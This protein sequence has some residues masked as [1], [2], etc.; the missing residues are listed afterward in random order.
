MIELQTSY[1]L[2]RVPYITFEALDDYAEDLI[3]D[4]MPELL[5]TPGWLNTDKFLEY[6][7]GLQA[8]YH[9]ICYDRKILGITAFSDG[10]LRV[11]DEDSGR[12]KKLPV[13]KGTVLIDSSLMIRWNRSRLRFTTM[14]ECSHW[15]LHKETFAED[16]PFKPVALYEE[17]YM[18]A[19][20][21]RADY[22][23]SMK[24]QT[25][26][27]RIE[28][29]ADFLAAAL[30]MPR[31]AL[32]I[33]YRNYFKLHGMKPRRIVIGKSPVDNFHAELLPFHVADEFGVSIIAARIRLEK[34]T[35][36]VRGNTWR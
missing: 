14:H 34:L 28:R 11:A 9:R 19:K 24:E 36:I 21:G 35:A 27:E 1:S 12:P 30:L 4:F 3:A 6:Y 17:Q 20:E 15:I 8:E 16:N 33:V 23:R 31:P 26:I 2:T 5:N 29:Q 32:R 7:L 22:S 13:T 10:V 18:A 25:D